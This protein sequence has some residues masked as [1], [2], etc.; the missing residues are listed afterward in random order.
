MDSNP[1]VR[2]GGADVLDPDDD[3]N[4]A[5]KLASEA[6]VAIVIVGLNS[7]WESEG[8]DR[9]T[10]S[11]PGRTDELVEKVIK[12]NPKTVVITQSV[13][14]KFSFTPRNRV[15]SSFPHLLS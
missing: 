12:V 1:G 9:T 5:V 8:Y 6:D 14:I 15:F 3:M 13:S 4:K 2:L 7:D 11:L 10:L